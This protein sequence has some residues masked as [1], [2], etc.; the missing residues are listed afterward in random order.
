M[1][2][3]ILIHGMPSKEEYFAHGQTEL[4]QHWFPWL[5][6]QLEKNHVNLNM[7]NMPVPYEPEYNAWKEVFEKFPLNEETVLI[8]HSCGGGFLIRYL[9]EN[10][11]RVGNVILVAPWLDLEHILQTGMFDFKIN[12]N[13]LTKAK[14]I[15]MFYSIDDYIEILKSV[16]KIKSEIP[17]I[18]TVEYT[19]RGHFTFEPGY[20][21]N[22]T[23]P[24]LLELVV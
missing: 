3:V 14:D 7:P 13:I 18:K 5:S 19:N 10:D 12:E 6:Q 8:G 21:I 1:K 20:E 16:E 15:K 22:K 23:F 2:N 4:N 9:S 24:E 17:G 11:V